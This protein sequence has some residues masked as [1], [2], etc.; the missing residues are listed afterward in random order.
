MLAKKQGLS[1]R[2]EV[3]PQIPTHEWQKLRKLSMINYLNMILV[4]ASD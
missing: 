4:R 3:A 2:D 1:L